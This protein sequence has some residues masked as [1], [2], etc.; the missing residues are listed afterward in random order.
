[1][2]NLVAFYD[3][4]TGWVDVVH[5]VY[6]AFSKVFDTVSHNILMTKL[7]KCGQMSGQ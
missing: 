5:V 1:M 4:V 7:R 3:V 6:L 2:T